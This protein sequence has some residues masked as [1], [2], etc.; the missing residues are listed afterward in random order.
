MSDYKFNLYCC[1]GVFWLICGLIA[2]YLYRKR[3][4]SEL[5]GCLGG[6][7]L[8]PLGI[9]LALVSPPDHAALARKEK[10]LE[11][12]RIR[13]GE[14][15]K[16]PYCAESIRPEA[17]VCRHCGRSLIPIP[18]APHQQDELTQGMTH[19]STSAMAQP[20]AGSCLCPSCNIPMEIRVHQGK[21]FY[22]CPNYKQCH[23][24]HSID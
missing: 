10:E 12:D 1:I 24:V 23:Q 17:K 5:I 16:C 19:T 7:L 13:R 2:G 9:I 18:S 11:V 22:V 4:R 8:G 15:K 14:L 20:D 6:F 3:G 21:Q